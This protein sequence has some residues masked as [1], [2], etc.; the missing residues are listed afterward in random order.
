MST[1]TAEAWAPLHWHTSS[2]ADRKH[3]LSG[4]QHQGSP[5]FQCRDGCSVSKG[6]IFS[7]LPRNS[8]KF[9][10]TNPLLDFHPASDSVQSNQ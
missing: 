10:R 2:L 3:Q 6:I 4:S 1:E 7:V 8:I 5:V 9:V